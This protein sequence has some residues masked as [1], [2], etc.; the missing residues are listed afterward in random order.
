MMTPDIRDQSRENFCSAAPEGSN[1]FAMLEVFVDC[2][3]F[4]GQGHNLLLRDFV[5]PLNTQRRHK[6]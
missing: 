6:D 1:A 5:M 2:I 3:K 4:H